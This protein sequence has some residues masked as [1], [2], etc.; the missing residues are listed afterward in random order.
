MKFENC[1]HCLGKGSVGGGGSIMP[2]TECDHC[3][4]TGYGKEVGSAIDLSLMYPNVMPTV[5]EMEER[6]KEGE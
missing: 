5:E 3:Y 1:E 4:G 6:L 2:E